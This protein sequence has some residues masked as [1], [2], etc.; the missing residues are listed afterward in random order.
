V[1]ET[2]DYRKVRS[3]YHWEGGVVESPNNIAK[4]FQSDR[5]KKLKK[6][7]LERKGGGKEYKGGKVG[8]RAVK[9]EESR[10]PSEKQGRINGDIWNAKGPLLKEKK[11]AWGRER[12]DIGHWLGESK[13][14]P[15]SGKDKKRGGESR[16]D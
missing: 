11:E 7:V 2:K 14:Q 1:G 4:R 5:Q 8:F 10:I 9:H 12:K 15:S 3:L 16:R 13:A 6:R